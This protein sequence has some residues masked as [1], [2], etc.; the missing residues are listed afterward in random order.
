M[1][2][3]GPHGPGDHRV[4]PI[5]S[6]DVEGVTI[7]DL[8]LGDV[9]DV[10]DSLGPWLHLDADKGAEELPVHV[11]KDLAHSLGEH[12][13]KEGEGRGEVV[14][15]CLWRYRI[16]KQPEYTQ[17]LA[18]QMLVNLVAMQFMKPA[19]DEAKCSLDLD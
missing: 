16:D 12:W 7:A 5:E 14:G 6:H 9:Q 2:S 8:L 1:S 18:N 3:S 15:N 4:Q 19:S 13:L 17:I 11:S 10:R